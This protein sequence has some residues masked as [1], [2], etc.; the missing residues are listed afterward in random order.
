[1]EAR[2]PC[3]I[4]FLTFNEEIRHPLQD[5]SE[6]APNLAALYLSIEKAVSLLTRGEG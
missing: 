3:E 1:M 4:N 5:G 6:Q 2:K